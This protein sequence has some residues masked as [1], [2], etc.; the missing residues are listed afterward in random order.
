MHS[1]LLNNDIDEYL[2]Y[3]SKKRK[4][5]KFTQEKINDEINEEINSPIKINEIFK[6][7]QEDKENEELYREEMRNKRK[8]AILDNILQ[9]IEN[10]ENTIKKLDPNN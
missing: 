10:L 5:I 8:I 7:I 9:N 1:L 2:E 6:K 3:C 4:N